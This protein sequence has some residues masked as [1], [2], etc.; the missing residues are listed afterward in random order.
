MIKEAEH[1]FGLSKKPFSQQRTFLNQLMKNEYTEHKLAAI[2]FLQLYGH[3]THPEKTLQLVSNWFDQHWVSDWNVCD[4]LCV[5]IL[6][7]LLDQSPRSALK[8]FQLWNKDP[9]L[10]KAR[11][12]LVPFAQCKSLKDHKNSIRD[13]SEILIQREERFCKTAVGWVM[14]EYSKIDQIFVRSFLDE[15]SESSTREVVR[16]ATKYM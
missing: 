1:Q 12:S 16:N 4:W 15:F 5:R 3:G 2:L 7:P 8:A 9:Y 11:A 13:L 14:R 10:W 6:S